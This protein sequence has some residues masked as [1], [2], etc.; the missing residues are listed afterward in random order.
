MVPSILFY[1]GS[2]GEI[3]HSLSDWGTAR[4]RRVTIRMVFIHF[5]YLFFIFLKDFISKGHHSE[6]VY[7]DGS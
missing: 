7:P 1:V 6:N 3:E 2:Y 4:Y 5:I